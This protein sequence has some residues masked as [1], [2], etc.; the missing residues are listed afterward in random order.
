MA[1]AIDRASSLEDFERLRELLVAYE[2]DLPVELRHGPVPSLE[3]LSGRYRGPNA[4]FIARLDATSAG[5]VVFLAQDASTGVPARLY[6]AP[7][8]RKHGAGRALV[9]AV[10]AFA[11]EGPYDRLVLDTH[12]E[13]LGLAYRLYISLGFVEY[14][15][16]CAE[17]T[18]ACSTFMRLSLRDRP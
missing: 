9:H 5:C 8:A 4:A 14:Q 15:P 7:H 2:E 6:V 18:G 10:M 17:T 16:P 1:V 12:R 11:H 13:L 3:E